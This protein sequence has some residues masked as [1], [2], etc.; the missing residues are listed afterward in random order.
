MSQ[1]VKARHP[2][3]SRRLEV[4]VAHLILRALLGGSLRS[5]HVGAVLTT[6]LRYPGPGVS[7]C[8]L[9]TLLTDPCLKYL[10][11]HCHLCLEGRSLWIQSMYLYFCYIKHSA[12]FHSGYGVAWLPKTLSCFMWLFCIMYYLRNYY[13]FCNFM[14]FD[15]VSGVEKMT[16]EN[17]NQAPRRAW[18]SI[19]R[20]WDHAL[21]RNQELDA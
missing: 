4:Q 19:L 18:G 16:H 2:G 17:L 6:V 8:N 1:F 21:N 7:S 14:W 5:A 10:K 3:T 9:F 13:V 20:P 15:R 11:G 12:G